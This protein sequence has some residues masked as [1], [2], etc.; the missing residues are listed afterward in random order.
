MSITHD[1]INLRLATYGTLAPGRANY[2]QLAEL[3][4]SWERGWVV[5]HLK[6]VGWGAGMGYPGLTLDPAGPR[7]EVHLFQSNDLPFHW[8]RLDRFEGDGYQRSAV[9]VE[10]DHG[11]KMAW[12]YV[13]SS[14]AE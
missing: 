5:G 1:L 9:S 4:G 6:N 8:E 12:I 11:R 2:H 7:V 14:A 10:T 3:E 13:L